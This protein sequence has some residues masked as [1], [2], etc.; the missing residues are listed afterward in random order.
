MARRHAKLGD[1]DFGR[2]DMHQVT[3][4]FG[5]ESTLVRAKHGAASIYIPGRNVTT[6]EAVARRI[7]DS[8]SATVSVRH[9][10][11]RML[12]DTE[13]LNVVMAN[14]GVMV[15]PTGLT[16][17]GY[18]AVVFE[19]ISIQVAAAT[20]DDA[21]GQA[22][23][24]FKVLRTRDGGDH[25]A[26]TNTNTHEDTLGAYQAADRVDCEEAAASAKEGFKQR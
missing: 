21:F 14:A 1:L 11:D 2:A 7:K 8:G 20:V 5:A 10:A 16:R 6:A 24:L 13:R 22:T 18:G 12:G 4:G 25:K 19:N 9:A 26:Q 3:N 17:L 23:T 15:Q